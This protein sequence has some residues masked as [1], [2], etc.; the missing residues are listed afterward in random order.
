VVACAATDTSASDHGEE[1]ADRG[2]AKMFQ[3]HVERCQ[4][5]VSFLGEDGPVVIARDGYVVGDLAAGCDDRFE[6]SG[7]DLVRATGEGVEVRRLG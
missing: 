2:G 6:G 7:C 4:C 3:F 1:V 5:G